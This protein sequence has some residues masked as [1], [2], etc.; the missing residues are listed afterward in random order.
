MTIADSHLSGRLKWNRC[1]AR[2]HDFRP[3]C[4][5]NRDDRLPDAIAQQCGLDESLAWLPAR[6]VTASF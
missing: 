4:G 2:P 3:P 1:W 6:E 5:A